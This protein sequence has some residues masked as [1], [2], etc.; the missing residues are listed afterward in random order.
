MKLQ[1]VSCVLFVSLV[2]STG[3][4]AQTSSKQKKSKTESTHRNNDDKKN[5]IT[6]ES[7]LQ[8]EDIIIGKGKEA[9]KGKQATVHCTGWLTN[10][11]KF[12]SSYDDAQP[13]PFTVGTGQ[14]IKGFDE[15]VQ[16]MKVGGKRKLIIPSDLAYGDGGRPGTIPPKATLIFEI[17]LLSVGQ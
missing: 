2:A 17:D 10:G 14:M 4:Q 9:V 8:Y 16:G 13:L 12:W 1:F 5:T 6:T 15:G 11:N 3:V 7:G